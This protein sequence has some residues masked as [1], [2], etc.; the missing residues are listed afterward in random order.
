[1]YYA[2]FRILSPD[3]VSACSF[4]NPVGSALRFDTQHGAARHF[5]ETLLIFKSR[6]STDVHMDE[7]KTVLRGEVYPIKAQEQENDIRES[8]TVLHT[9]QYN[10]S[11][12]II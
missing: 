1:M 9:V 2:V 10:S 12:N 6:Y 7:P 8:T 4:D 11:S 5:Q 3:L